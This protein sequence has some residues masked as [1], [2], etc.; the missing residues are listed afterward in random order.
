MCLVSMGQVRTDEGLLASLA[1]ALNFVP[2]GQE[3][4][5]AQLQ[6]YL[7]EKQLLL[8]LDSFEHAFTEWD[9]A[10]E[11]IQVLEELLTA[12]PGL[13]ALVTSRQR[14][15]LVGEHVLSV[16]GL[17][18]PTF[19]DV[20]VDEMAKIENYSAIKLFMRTARRVRPEFELR[21]E[22]AGVVRICQR[23]EGLPLAID[24]A[25]VHVAGMSA[26]DIADEIDK[27]LDVLEASGAFSAD[28]D[29]RHRSVRATFEYSWRMMTPDEQ[30]AFAQLSAFAGSFSRE[31]A[32]HVVNAPQRVLSGLVSN[33]LLHYD[34]KAGRYD[35]HDLL[36]QFAAEKLHDEGLG[37]SDAALFTRLSDYYLSFARRHQKRYDLLEP[38]WANFLAAMRVAH[39]GGRWQTLIEFAEALGD[40]WFTR[41]R[42]SDA[43]AGFA[44]AVEAARRVE[45]QEALA[46][47][48]R[49][50]AQAC[51]EQAGYAEAS[52]YLDEALRLSYEVEDESLTAGVLCDQGK[53]SLE[54]GYDD[55]AE[56]LLLSSQN[57]FEK[58]KDKKGLAEVIDLRG[59]VQNR[60]GRND[61]AAQ[62]TS[63]AIQ[64][65]A[66]LAVNERL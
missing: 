12:A 32:Q 14:L 19:V 20:D 24:L 40:T 30:R 57:I 63:Q 55:K 51:I 31:A 11:A 27:S 33:S 36:R 18:Y 42:F 22:R 2:Y 28:E 39:A 5:Q 17:D 56:K 4:L 29:P 13:K 16:E 48:L 60:L 26:S 52:G 58:F 9:S 6:N 47:H 1:N 21:D 23:A 65:R 8:V 43:R 7:R 50:H 66:K 38:E 54:L 35:V 49:R 45:N 53:I 59:R 41:A 44:L 25:A 64:L 61:L 46:A 10:T 15:R 37:L 3:P 62:L 34:F